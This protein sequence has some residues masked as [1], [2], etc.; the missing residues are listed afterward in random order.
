MLD[1]SLLLKIFKDMKKSYKDLNYM[2]GLI[3]ISI[4]IAIIM[5]II[6]SD[7]GAILFLFLGFI[8]MVLLFI[9]QDK[10]STEFKIIKWA[11]VILFVVIIGFTIS[12]I[13]FSK[14][15]N[16]VNFL[17]IKNTEYKISE[18]DKMI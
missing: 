11:I 8:S 15:D 7:K 9:F 18:K 4:G 10:K 17:G 13:A 2:G 6:G 14:P 5:K 3:G 12:A 1:L 16:W